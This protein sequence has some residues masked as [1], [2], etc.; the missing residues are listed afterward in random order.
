M[1]KLPRRGCLVDEVTGQ[2]KWAW[3][4]NDP[5]RDFDVLP[6]YIEDRF[7]QRSVA[8]P[9]DT[10]LDLEQHAEIGD[11]PLLYKDLASTRVRKD[12]QGVWRFKELLDIDGEQIEVD[13]AIETRMQQRAAQRA[14]KAAA[15]AQTDTP[16][17]NDPGPPA[18]P[19]ASAKP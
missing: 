3:E 17:G 1:A 15:Q 13:H 9:A 2:V 7:G 5:E 8:A 11:V 4:H 16:A 19:G 14:K 12:D 18:D 10:I 6:P